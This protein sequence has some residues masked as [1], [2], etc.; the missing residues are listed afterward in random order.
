MALAVAAVAAA[1]G[2][3]TQPTGTPG[4]VQYAALAA[5]AAAAGA[6][7]RTTQPAGMPGAVQ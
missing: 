1:A 7:G 5:A 6:A 4:A 3:A 2:F